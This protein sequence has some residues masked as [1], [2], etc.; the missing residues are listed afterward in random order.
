MLSLLRDYEREQVRLWHR[1]LCMSRH[2]L[3]RAPIVL[4]GHDQC[5]LAATRAP[6]A[7]RKQLEAAV[8]QTHPIDVLQDLGIEVP[9]KHNA[10]KPT[11]ANKAPSIRHPAPKLMSQHQ[12]FQVGEGS[13]CLH[14]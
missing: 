1:G 3:V 10:D 6:Q 14:W 5:M 8:K 7:L 4:S 9:V 12:F 13:S 11:G 2:S